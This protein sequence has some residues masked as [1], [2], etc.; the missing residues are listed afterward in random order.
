[1]CLIRATKPQWRSVTI[2][3]YLSELRCSSWRIANSIKPTWGALA[4]GLT[5][6]VSSLPPP[7]IGGPIRYRFIPHCPNHCVHS[8]SQMCVCK[9]M[10]LRT[11]F[12]RGLVKSLGLFMISGT[13][14][15]F[16]QKPRSLMCVCTI[17]LNVLCTIL[18]RGLVEVCSLYYDLR[19]NIFK[20]TCHYTEAPFSNVCM[21]HYVTLYHLV[22]RFGWS[23]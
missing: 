20:A 6:N 8:R 2:T 10:L 22:Q 16:I 23:L 4:H 19:Y 12:P 9:I 17:M 5:L 21:H 7:I 18:Y 1:M 13:I 14:L 11:I 15:A 3:L